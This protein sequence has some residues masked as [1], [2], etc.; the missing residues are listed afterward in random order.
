MEENSLSIISLIVSAGF[1]VKVVM[2]ILVLMSLYS[3]TVIMAKKKVLIDAKSDIKT[4]Q[5]GRAHV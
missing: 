4:F 2:A 5:I 3:W 1:V